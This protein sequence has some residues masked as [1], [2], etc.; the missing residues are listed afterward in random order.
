MLKSLDILIGFS[1]VMLLVSIP[2]T[3]LTQL[4]TGALGWRGRHLIRGI[5]TI[6]NQIDPKITPF[7]LN[8]IATAALRH[9]LIARAGGKIGTVIQREELTRILLELAAGQEP[10][11]KSLD[12]YARSTLKR[13]LETNGIANPAEVLDNIHLLA[14]KLEALRPELPAPL[15]HSIAVVTEAPSQFAGR[16][17][18]CFDETMDRVTHRFARHTRLVAGVL[19][20][21][22]AAG[23][24]L[25]ALDLL[26]R[27]AAGGA[28]AYAI[29]PQSRSWTQLPGIALSAMLL[30]LGA[31]FWYNALK[32]LVGFRPV[33]ARKE[34][35]HREQRQSPPG[36]A[37]SSALSPGGEKGD[38][39]LTG[40][41][42]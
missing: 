24:Q 11:G 42:G 38:L 23:L 17:H 6:L 18:A 13:A 33:L 8:Q 4:I 10:G 16:L 14:L 32:D 25:D 22:V 9:P 30:S 1:V 28:A 29:L 12:E 35:A 19:A 26:R 41:A 40:A 5:V 20:I 2:V 37:V 27:L 21:L 31:P 34:Q 7:C 3:V 39:S 15:R 36:A